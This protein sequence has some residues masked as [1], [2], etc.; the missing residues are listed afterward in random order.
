MS[1]STTG[2]GFNYPLSDFEEAAIID[3]V[4]FTGAILLKESKLSSLGDVPTKIL[5]VIASELAK[6]LSIPF[7]APFEAEYLSVNLKSTWITRLY[8]N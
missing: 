2:T 7:E 4:Q 6:P 5:K 1:V 8:K 3:T